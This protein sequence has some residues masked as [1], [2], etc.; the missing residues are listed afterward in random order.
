M[1]ELVNAANNRLL[2][3]KY[4]FYKNTLFFHTNDNLP[5]PVLFRTSRIRTN[6]IDK[7]KNA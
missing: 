4:S 1:I 3:K 6:L 7:I 5:V 2:L